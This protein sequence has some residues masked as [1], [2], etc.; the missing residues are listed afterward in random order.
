MTLRRDG[1]RFCTANIHG[2]NVDAAG[3]GGGQ[4]LQRL[5]Y[6]VGGGGHLVTARGGRRVISGP[7]PRLA[8][9]AGVGTWVRSLSG[10]RDYPGA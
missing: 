4:F 8:P 6:Q 2:D 5:L 10:Y 3:M 1:H 9:V 7:M